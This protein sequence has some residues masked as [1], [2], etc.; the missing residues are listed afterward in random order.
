MYRQKTT[1]M[2]PMKRYIFSLFICLIITGCTNSTELEYL[3]QVNGTGAA[4]YFGPWINFIKDYLFWPYAIVFAILSSRYDSLPRFAHIALSIAFFISFHWDFDPLRAFIIP[5]YLCMPL[6]YVP[7]IKNEN[8]TILSIGGTTVAM[9]FLCYKA[10]G[11]EGF[12]NWLID[13]VA[14][15]IC[16]YGGLLAFMVYMDERCPKCG[17]FCLSMRGAT[18]KYKGAIEHFRNLDS[19]G[20]DIRE[21]SLGDPEIDP[22]DIGK[23]CCPHCMEYTKK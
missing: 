19:E 12:F 18:P 21:V 7:Y 3:R 2:H 9:L 14:W 4:E 8:L 20:F 5:Y 6:V 23:Q 16:A 13:M 17:H 22:K 1:D 15:I 10:W 11:Y